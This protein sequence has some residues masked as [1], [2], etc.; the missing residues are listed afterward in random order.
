[1]ELQNQ[2]DSKFV[3]QAKQ[4]CSADLLPAEIQN[5]KKFASWNGYL[6][7][8]KNAIIKQTLSNSSRQ[9][10]LYNYD[11]MIKVYLNLPYMGNAGE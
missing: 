11:D 9:G 8:I 4:I 6:K 5:N 7:F 10:H 2:L 3:T 1:M